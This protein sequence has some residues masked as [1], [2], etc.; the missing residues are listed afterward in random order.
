MDQIKLFLNHHHFAPSV[1]QTQPLRLSLTLQKN[2][3]M[4]P[5]KVFPGSKDLRGIFWL[6]GSDGK[7]FAC[8]SGDLG[9]IPGLERSP[10]G[11]LG[12]P[13]QYSCLEKPHGQ[14]SLA[15]CSPWG[16]KE[17]DVTKGLST[18]QSSTLKMG[19]G[20]GVA[21]VIKNPLDRRPETRVQSRD[22]EDPLEEEMATLSSIFAW[23]IPWTE[24]PEW[25]QSIGSQRV[26]H[27]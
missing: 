6:G 9:S 7:E 16:C 14:R 5:N 11:G 3:E 21:L 27:D 20:H 8:N 15:G 2:T 19:E 24:E 1:K 25:L 4:L 17:L 22:R 26:G 18:A 10:G 23:R 13:F 12:N